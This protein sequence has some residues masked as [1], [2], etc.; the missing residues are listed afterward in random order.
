MGNLR[1]SIKSERTFS[2]VPGS[3]APARLDRHRGEAL[4]HH[5]LSDD[6]V[7]LPEGPVQVAI[8]HR[9]PEGDVGPELGMSQRRILFQ[10]LFR[11]AHDRERVEV[12]FNQI[13]RVARHV[14]VLGNNDGYRMAHE[15]NA[16]SR[17]HGV[18]WNS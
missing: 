2:G 9:P 18:L 11:V 8:G 3:D 12:H 1:R 17:Q 7:G 6:A 15:V 5:S 13:Q 16:V 10:R 4:V 14:A